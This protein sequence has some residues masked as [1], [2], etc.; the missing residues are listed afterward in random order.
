MGY[1]KTTNLA[2]SQCTSTCLDIVSCAGVY[3]TA[4]DYCLL[5]SYTTGLAYSLQDTQIQSTYFYHR[6]EFFLISTFCR[7]NYSYSVFASIHR[8]LHFIYRQLYWRNRIVYI[9][10]KYSITITKS[11]LFT[12]RLYNSTYL[13][14]TTYDN[15]CS[16]STPSVIDT[17]RIEEKTMVSKKQLFASIISCE[18]LSLLKRPR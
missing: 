18:Y 16:S 6:S 14:F 15:I 4:Q 10:I 8:K 2:Y 5:L 1:D 17:T 7:P 11:N 13:A 3:V 9:I 12:G